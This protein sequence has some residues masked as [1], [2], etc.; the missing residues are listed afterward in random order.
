MAEAAPAVNL[1]ER[2]AGCPSA[3][4]S[5]RFIAAESVLLAFQSNFL[6][7]VDRREGACFENPA[8]SKSATAGVVVWRRGKRRGRWKVTYQCADRQRRAAFARGGGRCNL[9]VTCCH[10]K[11]LWRQYIGR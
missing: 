10:D 9:R 5:L 2:A 4:T 6:P 3:L 7:Q 8:A 11:Q 1:S